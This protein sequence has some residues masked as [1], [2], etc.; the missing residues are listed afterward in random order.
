MQARLGSG[1]ARKPSA[2]VRRLGSEYTP[3]QINTLTFDAYDSD[4]I[5]LLNEGDAFVVPP[6]AITARRFSMCTRARALCAYVDNNKSGFL[7]NAS[8]INCARANGIKDELL[9]G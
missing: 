1:T 7:G 5:F 3:A 8:A 2:A 6:T 4:G 9:I